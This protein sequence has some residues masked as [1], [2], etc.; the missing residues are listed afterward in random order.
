MTCADSGIYISSNYGVDW[1]QT[2]SNLAKSG[3]MSYNGEYMAYIDNNNNAYISSDYGSSWVLTISTSNCVGISVSSSTGQYQTAVIGGNVYTSTSYGINFIDHNTT[4]NTNDVIQINVS[5]QG[6]NQIITNDTDVFISQNYGIDWNSQLTI[7][8]TGSGGGYISQSV[9]G[10][11]I[12]VATLRNTGIYYSTAYGVTGSWVLAPSP[13]TNFWNGTIS[14]NGSYILYTTNNTGYFYYAANPIITNP[15][16]VNN[17]AGDIT[18]GNIYVN[19]TMTGYITTPSVQFNDGTS[20]T[21][22]NLQLYD[23]SFGTLW[24]ASNIN[25]SYITIQ[26]SALSY[27]GQYQTV[28]TAAGNIYASTNYGVTGS[29]IVVSPSTQ[30]WCGLSMSTTGQYQTATIDKLNGGNSGNIF[31]STNYGLLG[32]WFSVFPMN[33]NWESTSMSFTGQYQIAV[34]TDGGGI[35]LSTNYGALNSWGNVAPSNQAWFATAVSG[36]GQYQVVCVNGGYIYVSSNYGAL[37]TWN[38]VTTT[39]QSWTKHMGISYTGQYQVNAVNGGN[40]YLSTSYGA[41]NTWY[42]VTTTPQAWYSV[43][44]SLTGKYVAAAVNGGN[45]Y[46]STNYGLSNSWYIYNTTANGY[47]V[48]ISGNGQYLI[49][50]TNSLAVSTFYTSITP[51]YIF[52]PLVTNT[53]T[54][55]TGYITGNLGI[56]VASPQAPLDVVAGPNK[57]VNTTTSYYYSGSTP[58]ITS[59]G[60][61]LSNFS[62]Y[63]RGSILTTGSV[64]AA[65][66]GSFSD[67]RIKKNMIDLSSVDTASI[68]SQ[69]IP[70]KYNY[71]DTF[72]HSSIPTYGFIAQDVEKII[73]EAVSIMDGYIPNIYEIA[74]ISNNCITLINKTTA[75]FIYDISSN[76]NQITNTSNN[77]IQLKLYDIDNNEYITTITNIQDEKT[78]LIEDVYD[79]SHIFVYGQSVSDY[80]V[81]DKDIIFTMTTSSVIKLNS[82]VRSLNSQVESLTNEVSILK[83]QINTILAKN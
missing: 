54:T 40:I 82:Q 60:N 26:N 16:Q 53:I 43:A 33:Q 37:N 62:I 2:I 23:N 57:N 10:Q 15:N 4:I 36:T 46:L 22:S 41:Y 21:S 79:I 30:N 45:I 20:I 13:V 65:T 76:T 72:T 25:L 48:N 75:D 74:D 34:N 17:T 69:I 11:Y 7:P 27:N 81:V 44:M 50:G 32:T 78:F 64:V 67:S 63:A 73:P 38:Q 1:Y 35:Y 68:L 58:S 18:T 71:I 51:T 9:N 31:I 47:S 83:D 8:S 19:K 12:Y 14:G 56:G 24:N 29:W 70:V 39:V 80:R 61:L 28:T 42:Q 59:G 55:S 52:Q 6:M 49:Y 3:S 77:K 66:T 5:A